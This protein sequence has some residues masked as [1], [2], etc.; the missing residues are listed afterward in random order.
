MEDF[1]RLNNKES[2]HIDEAT[3]QSFQ[4][5]GARGFCQNA[6]SNAVTQHLFEQEAILEIVLTT[7]FIKPQSAEWLVGMLQLANVRLGCQEFTAHI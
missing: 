5:D 1:K 6:H 2:K 3:L 4:L 7:T